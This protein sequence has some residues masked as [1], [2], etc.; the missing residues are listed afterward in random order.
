MSPKNHSRVIKKEIS[1]AEVPPSYAFTRGERALF[2]EIYFS[3]KSAYQG[4]IFTALQEG[5]NEDMV[6]GYFRDQIADL[7]TELEGYPH[8]F[9]PGYYETARRTRRTRPPTREEAL[10]RIAM[11]RSHFKGWSIYEVAGVFLNESQ[12]NIDEEQAQ[13]VRLMF[14]LR[15][16]FTEEAQTTSCPDVLQAIIR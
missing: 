12:R 4:P 15:S 3:R 14:R 11:Y 6:K 7:L 13:V 9:D 16:S 10:E 5:L 1:V 2:V 8:L